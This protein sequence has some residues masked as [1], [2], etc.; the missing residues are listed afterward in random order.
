MGKE[1]KKTGVAF[2]ERKSW[3]HRTKTLREDGTVKYGKIGGF[4]TQEEA[5][6]SYWK[7]EEEFTKQQRE[8]Q[9]SR[10]ANP[11]ILLKD[12]LIFWFENVYSQRIETTTRM[13]GAYTLYDLLLPSM[14]SDIK[15]RHLSV[16]YLDSLLERAS[17]LCASAGNQA[18][19]FLG[20][21]LKDAYHDK[22]ISYNPLPET[23]P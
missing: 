20:I 3:Y 15:M 23:K 12:Y 18:R 2:F 7:Y 17:K 13:L 1:K 16:E 19:N 10:Q 8:Y 4:A 11:D 14:E 5:E 6:E 21:A 9:V 22:Y